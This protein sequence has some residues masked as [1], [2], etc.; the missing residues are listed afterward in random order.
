[1]SAERS[2]E[3]IPIWPTKEEFA[4]LVRKHMGV[5]I[6]DTETTGLDVRGPRA[7][8]DAKYVGLM[9]QGS[10]YCC[11][12]T[13]PRFEDIR[14]TVENLPL[15]GHNLR[16]DLH[17]LSLDPKLPI[18]D[19]MV[20]AY[21]RNTV[22]RRSLDHLARVYGWEK[23]KTP[24]LIKKGRIM[25]LDP[26]DVADY[27][28]DDCL[29]TSRVFELQH[30]GDLGQ[31]PFD[32]EVERAVYNMES[33]G[34]CLLEDKLERLGARIQGETN[35]ILVKLRREELLGD[36]NSPK[37]VA[38]WLLWRGRKLPKTPKGNWSTA[39]T[40]LQRLADNGDELVTL[41]LAYRR[42]SK[43]TSAFIEP[44]PR[45]T[46]AN[47]ML[48]PQVNT[49]RT[50]TGR[51]S[52]SEPNLQQIPKRG[53]G[54]AKEFRKCFTSEFGGVTVADY[55]QVELRVAAALAS[56]PVLLHA[57]DEGGDPHAEVAATMLGKKVED[58]TP[59]ERFKAKA[60]N[61][62]ILNGMGAKRLALELKSTYAHA[63]EFLGNYKRSLPRLAE[64]MEGI[65]TLAE[66]EMVARTASGRMRPFGPDENTR[67]AISVVVQGT[68]AEIMRRSLVAVDDEGLDPILVVHDEI[69]VAGKGKK[70]LLAEIMQDAAE[71][72][73]PEELDQVA[74]PVEA[75]HGDTWGH[76]S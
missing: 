60:V 3:A 55:S 40:A 64:W 71:T 6:M 14:A 30:R 21:F 4:A 42:H 70:E 45:M 24:D 37:Q 28:A 68:A 65:W 23:I 12:F 15:V 31:A 34:V 56:E 33:R 2:T 39:K 52:Y 62:G 49:T 32:Y 25:E 41:L 51:F 27:L 20:T 7:Q 50:K 8:H 22:G 57:F 44:L 66:T 76:A 46:R 17:A 9:P 19:T 61:F 18:E 74:F 35:D 36:P 58:I 11:I 1:V 72:T 59:E 10:P 69:V 5:W 29:I 54:L 75:S 43:L 67:S 63:A 48:Y 47:G 13:R 38:E 73:F 26:H 53:G 16:F